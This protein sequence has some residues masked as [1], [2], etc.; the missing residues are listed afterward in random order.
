MCDC[1]PHT[2][3]KACYW[4]GWSPESG[5]NVEHS[6]ELAEGTEED[7]FE[8]TSGRKCLKWRR[9]ANPT[10]LAEFYVS[11]RALYLH[12]M[13]R[14]ETEDLLLL[15]SPV[16][17]VLLPWMGT[18]EMWVIRDATIPCLCYGKISG[19]QAWPIRCSSLLSLVYIA[20]NLRAICPKC[21][22]TQL[23]PALWWTSCM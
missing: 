10:E 17:I 6:V 13:P 20:C 8:G 4:L 9:F 15:W 7:R 2:C 18:T 11:S 14:C 16:P 23:W 22:Y 19:G 3:T 1:R 21:L 5:P 12:S